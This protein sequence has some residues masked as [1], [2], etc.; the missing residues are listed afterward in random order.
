METNMEKEF[1]FMQGIK[2]QE[3][4]EYLVLQEE[5]PTENMRSPVC[6]DKKTLPTTNETSIWAV[7]STPSLDQ[8]PIMPSFGASTLNTHSNFKQKLPTNSSSQSSFKSLPTSLSMSPSRAPS[9]SPSKSPSKPS[10]TVKVFARL[11]FVYQEL[12]AAT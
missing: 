1:L 3:N 2:V 12:A 4:T 7:T 5:Q 11:L 10:S 9:T 6:P 8:V